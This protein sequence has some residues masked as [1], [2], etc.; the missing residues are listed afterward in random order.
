VGMGL[1]SFPR[2]QTQ[3]VRSITKDLKIKTGQNIAID[4]VSILWNGKL[5]F[6]ELLVSDHHNDTLLF[7]KELSTSIQD[8]R[9]LINSDFNF[10]GIETFNVFLNIKKYP[11][12]ES[13]SLKV[14]LDKFKKQSV[15]KHASI[16]K[17][18]EISASRARFKYTDLNKAKSNTISIQDIEFT[19]VDFAYEVDSFSFDLKALDGILES[20][21]DQPFSFEGNVEYSPGILEFFNFDFINNKNRIKGS[22]YLKGKNNTFEEFNDNVKLILRINEGTIYFQDFLSNKAEFISTSPYEISLTASGSL[23]DLTLHNILL[24]N[25]GFSFSGGLDFKHLF[26]E[27]ETDWSAI[28]DDLKLSS[29]SFEDLKML[30]ILQKQKIKALGEVQMKG[31]LHSEE[32]SFSMSLASANSWGDFSLVGALGKG[33]ITA[34]AL[35]RKVDLVFNIKK[36]LI[37]SFTGQKTQITLA[38]KLLFSGDFPKSNLFVASWKGTNT[39]MSSGNHVWDNIKFEGLFRNNQLRN[40][41][42]INSDPI[43]LK[44][45][46]R[47]DYQNDIPEYT[48][49]A[50]IF[51]FDLNTLGLQLGEGKRVFKGVVSANLNGQN[52]DNLEG[53]VKIS[54]ASIVNDFNQIKLNPISIEKQFIDNKTFLSI[55]NTD[56][57]SGN[58][59]GEFKLSE[60]SKLFQNAL[61]QAYPFLSSKTVSK[62]QYLTFDLKIYKKVL[63]A[64]YPNFSISENIKLKGKIN[65]DRLRSQLILDSPLLRWNEIQFKNIHFQ[66]DTKNPLYNTFLSVGEL[67]HEYYSGREFNMISTQFQDTL[68]FRSEFIGDRKKTTPFEV[69]FYHTQA[70][71]ATSYFGLKKSKLPMGKSV[72]TLNP[73]DNPQQKLSYSPQNKRVKV[74][75]FNAVSEQQ[76]IRFSGNYFNVNDFMF[77]LATEKVLLENLLPFSKIFNLE[78]STSLNA[79]IERSP[80]VNELS[81]NGAIKALKINDQLMGDFNLDAS[82]NTLINAYVVNSEIINN[83]KKSFILKGV[84][85]GLEMPNLNFDFNFFDLDLDFL[86]P[87]GREA[88]KDFTGLVEGSANLWGP[89]D[90]LKHNGSLNLKKGG[91]YIP[92]LNLDYTIEDTDIMLNDQIFSF[93]NVFMKDSEEATIAI[94]NGT[95]SHNNFKNWQTN[96]NISSKR[97]LLLNTLQ[98]EESLFFGKGFLGGQVNIEGP[99]KN[100]IISLEGATQNGTSIKIPWAENYG[101]SE[102]SFISFIDKNKKLVLSEKSEEVVINEIKGVEMNFD[103]DVTNQAEVEIVIDQETGSY[104]RGRGGGNLFM[105]INTNGK[106]NM[107]GDFITFDGIYNFKNLGIIDKKFN[108]KPGGTI[109]WEGNP[110]EAK[111]DLEAIYDVPGGANPALLLDNPNFNKKIPTEVLIRLEGNLLKPDNPIFEINFPNTSGIVAS[112]INYRLADPQRSQ[113]QALSLLSQGIF[114]NEV[115]VSMQGITNNLY[116]KASDIFSDLIGEENDKLKVGID[117]LQGDKSALLDIATE[118][119]L[120]FTLSTKISDRILL[121]GKIGV[122]VGGLQQT[123]IVGNVQIDF[124]LNDEG[125]LRAK[126]FNKENEFRYIGDELGYTQGVGI[127]YEVDFETFKEFIHKITTVNMSPID[128]NISEINTEEPS[129]IEFVKKN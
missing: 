88:L 114:I 104:L 31:T 96:L 24:K 123:L 10:D 93:S 78:G 73:N 69:N 99:I 57:I 60:L 82:G 103:L 50:N 47:F 117:Y 71:N 101:L 129:L 79:Y 68:Y 77:S 43:V 112:E 55:S 4:K 36:L 51:K 30:S 128:S 3:I 19:V 70:D 118:D 32:D 76:T 15:K 56:C 105:E 38:S 65:S 42:T 87:F 9:K 25:E 22:L 94:M 39:I 28:I 92:Y 110:L 100:L 75:D 119:R 121:N 33:F 97:M 122:P 26:D 35:N 34:K 59:T 81:F 40:T 11:N 58:A 7:V 27:H 108:V 98:T 53:Q 89:L 127:S 126:V 6:S 66:I 17:S 54:S 13:H 14:L 41:L 80:S 102:T 29:E 48:I 62:G 83:T 95:F 72:W 23:N 61:H 106:F 46:V 91:F 21:E 107:W 85:E 113:L 2:F 37:D 1:L 18:S 115:S 86:S 120:G 52:I 124:I 90:N 111:M 67:S 16:F 109:V 125:S 84:W 8:F 12:E 74:I 49:L 5:K 20:P 44:S 116:Q 63:D 64:L 45:D